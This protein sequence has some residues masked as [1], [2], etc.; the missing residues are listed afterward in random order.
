MPGSG[1]RRARGLAATGIVADLD[2]CDLRHELPQAGVHR[3]DHGRRLGAAADIGLVRHDHERI[4]GGAQR[5]TGR[6]HAEKQLKF[7]QRGR[8]VRLAVADDGY[9]ERAVAVEEHRWKSA[10]RIS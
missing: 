6:R 2:A 1:L 5:A 4:A 8:R 9:V 3:L 10:A 7:G